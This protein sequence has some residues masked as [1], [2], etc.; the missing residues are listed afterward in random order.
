MRTVSTIAVCRSLENRAAFASGA[1]RAAT[2]TALACLCCGAFAI[3]ARA[4]GAVRAVGGSL[5]HVVRNGD[6]LRVREHPANAP[7]HVSVAL[8]VREKPELDA[9]IAAA[10]TPG[11]PGY[12]KYLSS[13]EYM[14]RFAPTDAQVSAVKSWLRSERLQVTGSSK[15]NLLVDAEGS[16]ATL[17]HT[18]GVAIED[19]R[20]GGREFFSSDRAPSA[21]ADLPVAAVT[22]LSDYYEPVADN[23]CY[24]GKCGFGEVELLTRYGIT[25]EAQGQT[26]AF[27]LWGKSVP[28]STYE[29]YAKSDPNTPALGIGPGANQIEFEGE[30]STENE[31][32]EV[33][34]DTEA[35]HVLARGAHLEYFLAKNQEY[36]LSQL[37]EAVNSQATVISN[38][39]EYEEEGKCEGFAYEGIE[40][41]LE[42]GAA[43]GKTIFFS[44]GDHGAAHGC[45]YPSSSAYAVAVG[46]TGDVDTE[47]DTI[48]SE[49][50]I[51]NGGN[52]NNAVPRPSW[53]TGVGTPDVYPKGSCTGRVTPDVSALSCGSDEERVNDEC[54]LESDEGSWFGEGGT[55]LAAPIWAA[56]AAVWNYEDAQGGRPGIG[57]LD[58]LLYSLANDPTTYG[59]DFHDITEGSNGFAATGGWDEATGWGTPQWFRLARNHATL[60]YTGERESLPGRTV[61]LQAQLTDEGS[62]Q[63]LPGRAV[64]F[65]VGPDSCE[66]STNSSG[67]A[68]CNVQFSGSPGAYTV[69]A[70]V[71]ATAAYYEASASSAF[72]FTAVPPDPHTIGG[73]TL[74]DI[75]LDG[76]AGTSFTVGPGR[77]LTLDAK[78]SDE[79]KGCPGCID[80]VTLAF[81]GQPAAGCVE[82]GRYDGEH[83][84]AEVDL[85]PA[86]RKPGTYDIAA[87]FEEVYSCGEF[88]NAAGSSSYP[89]LAEVTVPQ[90]P[91]WYGEGVRLQEGVAETVKSKGSLTLSLSG[92]RSLSCAATGV[93]TLENPAGGEPGTDKMTE[94]ALSGCKEASK[95]TV[96]AKSEK[97]KVAVGGLPWSSE[98]VGGA[99]IRD[100]LSNVELTI[101]CTKAGNS[102]EI[103]VLK[104]SLTPEMGPSALEFGAGSGEL[105]ETLGGTASISGTDRLTGPHKDKT[106]TAAAP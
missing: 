105:D 31:T 35:A 23:H 64:R 76:E 10:S 106:I 71:A 69:H 56:V 49:F 77:E 100:E 25:E 88:W 18:F 11:G 52:C 90:P 86:P 44:T 28:E 7:L 20:V 94:L 48:N 54:F 97:P 2:V 34:L 87:N 43:L 42:E 32:T 29:E 37:D 65:T 93:E 78:W 4:D 59:K 85:G 103:D 27:T 47:Y 40:E 67:S 68:T 73:T 84:E 66:A 39:W 8:A 82:P 41:I 91:H 80:F 99:P 62:S 74:S 46:G 101:T 36:V 5:P 12:G 58:P 70:S 104:G 81:A 96:C 51:D 14:A 38:S 24:A 6:A 60:T 61:R 33:A 50:A 57:F 83:G 102:K 16:T 55:S 75:R 98:L 9:A 15:D 13:A 89:V 79:N 3:S 45:T 21:P 19:Y 72:T 26:I 95:G 92:S 1:L 17:E 63:P 22:G 30:P 53:Q